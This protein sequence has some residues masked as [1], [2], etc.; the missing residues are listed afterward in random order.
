MSGGESTAAAA[1]GSLRGVVPL[2]LHRIVQGP[3]GEWEDVHEEQLRRIVAHVGSRAATFCRPHPGEDPRWLLTFDDGCASDYELVFPLLMEAGVTATFFLISDWVGRPGYLGWEQVKEMHRHGMCIGSHGRTHRR[4]TDL[5]AEESAA[6]F[7]DSK[8]E[9]EDRLGA[10]VEL[11]S[12]PL[13]GNDAL[14]REQ[15]FAAGYSYLCGSS[16]GVVG[17]HN[18]VIPRN[19]IHSA[20]DWPAIERILEPG[21]ATRF[22]W[23]AEDAV[24]RVAKGVMGDALYRRLRHGVMHGR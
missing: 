17:A 16:H 10:A 12:F 15:G 18:R 6:E 13:G 5:S 20:M 7:A 11:F 14:R 2:V 23:Y 8:R 4:L 24:K 9:L 22:R 21:P 3:A 19:S 1:G